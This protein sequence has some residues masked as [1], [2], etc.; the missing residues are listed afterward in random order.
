LAV[1]IQQI[2]Y[3]FTKGLNTST[4]PHQN[5]GLIQLD[6]AWL[7]P[8][9]VGSVATI[10]GITALNSDLGDFR[11]NLIYGGADTAP[12]ARPDKVTSRFRVI[13]GSTKAWTIKPDGTTAEINTGFDDDQPWNACILGG[14]MHFYS[15][16]TGANK[17]WKSTL[18]IVTPVVSDIGLNRP[19]VVGPPAA[20][21]ATGA[22]APD[23]K[24]IVKYWVSHISGTTEGPLSAEF[25]EIDAGEGVSIDLS[26]IPLSGGKAKIYR[27]YRDRATP[28]FLAETTSASYNDKIA[29]IE[30]GDPPLLHG[31]PPGEAHVCAVYLTRVWIAGGNFLYWSDVDEPES[32]WNAG[33]YVVVGGDDGDIISALYPTSDGLYIFK[34][35]HIYKLI[36]L[37]SEDFRVINL[38]DSDPVS[39]VLG[40]PSQNSVTGIPGGVAFYYKNRIYTIIANQVK[41]ISGP[42]RND[43][44]TISNSDEY[45]ELALGY[46]PGNSILHFSG[47]ISASSRP[48]KTYL[49][50]LDR[51]QWIGTMDRGFRGFLATEDA[52]NNLV[53]WGLSAESSGG[54]EESIVY[55]LYNGTD[56]NGTAISWTVEL[57]RVI[58][59]GFN[60][61]KRLLYVD[62]EFDPDSSGSMSVDLTVDGIT[63]SP[64]TVSVDQ[65]DAGIDDL[66]V[67]RVNLGWRFKE[68]RCKLSGSNVSRVR[69]VTYGIQVLGESL[70]R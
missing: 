30:L 60:V 67:K 37:T 58:G 35:N 18:D 3:E 25:G 63:A 41:E 57:P 47:P 7:D 4:N 40:T 6:N 59:P 2:R 28:F 16:L 19:D 9:D 43:L 12:A 55:E 5:E 69:A 34:E 65:T 39:R 11:L 17:P 42:I 10:P 70:S 48:N 44:S 8:D 36:G 13:V 53:F 26:N 38:T 22:G 1:P 52:N 66:T 46:F 23:P 27:S 29:D 15:G 62:I 64:K 50:D 54:V 32:F 24:G 61:M 49:Y 33:N 20:S 68:L 56:Y 21:S 31:D 14:F 45:R 51:R